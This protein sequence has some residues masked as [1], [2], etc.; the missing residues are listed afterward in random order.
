MASVDSDSEEK[1]DNEFRRI[2]MSMFN[3]LKKKTQGHEENNEVNV[4][5]GNRF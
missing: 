3:N 2:I 4:R 1:A 5:H